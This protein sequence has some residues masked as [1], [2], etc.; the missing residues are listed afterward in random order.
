MIEQDQG[1]PCNITIDKDGVWYY[2]GAEMF[3]KD[4]L[5]LFFD[6][7]RR[8]DEGFYYVQMGAEICY[9]AVE[10]TPIVVRAVHCFND[11]ECGKGIIMLLSDSRVETVNLSSL[12]INADNVMYCDLERGFPARFT[13]SAY[14]QLADHIKCDGD[15]KYYIEANGNKYYIKEMMEGKNA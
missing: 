3:R 11:T 13:R 4:I 12:R 9:L 5:E 10:D 6:S 7:L 14:Y 8:D 2:N 15:E 1:V